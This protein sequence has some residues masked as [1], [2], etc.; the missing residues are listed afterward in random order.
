MTPDQ[1]DPRVEAAEN[2]RVETGIGDVRAV[3]HRTVADRLRAT[4]HTWQNPDGTLYVGADAVKEERL[5]GHNDLTDAHGLPCCYSDPLGRD[6]VEPV[7]SEHLTPE[8]QN[9]DTYL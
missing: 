8:E 5:C 4:G 2:P 9:D 1:H 7:P 3:L 6:A